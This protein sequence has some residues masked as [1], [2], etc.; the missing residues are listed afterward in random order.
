MLPSSKRL[1]S[2]EVVQVQKYGAIVSSPFVRIKYQKNGPV[3]RFA[4]VVSKKSAKSAVLR[5]V[6]RRRLYA[7]LPSLQAG[8]GLF[9]INILGPSKEHTGS[10]F[11]T[12]LESLFAKIS[13]T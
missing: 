13:K 4:V 11:Q 10:F 9:V 1:R 7:V 3:A 5:N 6:L 2:R 8:P 12:E